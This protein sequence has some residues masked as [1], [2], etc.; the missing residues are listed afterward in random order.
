MTIYVQGFFW[1]S[2]GE[3]RL[4]TG[5]AVSHQGDYMEWVNT[6]IYSYGNKDL[7]K[8]IHW[9]VGRHSALAEDIIASAYIL[10]SVFQFEQ[11]SE[12]RQCE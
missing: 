11:A 10:R 1:N 4:K 2:L 8:W 9:K 7:T 3:L 5:I 12:R 6:F